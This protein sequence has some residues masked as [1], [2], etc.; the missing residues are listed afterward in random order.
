MQDGF[1]TNTTHNSTIHAV[2]AC[3][4]EG[5]VVVYKGNQ[6]GDGTGSTLNR[7][8]LLTETGDISVQ[9]PR[10]VDGH[11][12]PNPWTAGTFLRVSPRQTG[13]APWPGVGAVFREY[14]MG[15]AQTLSAAQRAVGR[16]G[17]IIGARRVLFRLAVRLGR[18]VPG[19]TPLV[20]PHHPAQMAVIVSTDPSTGPLRHW[21]EKDPQGGDLPRPEGADPE[22]NSTNTTTPPFQPDARRPRDIGTTAGP[23]GP[24]G[25][26]DSD[27][28]MIA[29]F[30]TL[31]TGP[32]DVAVFTQG[33]PQD[34]VGLT[35]GRSLIISSFSSSS[36]GRRLASLK[37]FLIS[38]QGKC[39][40][41]LVFLAIVFAEWEGR[42]I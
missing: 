13:W 28:T 35:G 2:P 11:R 25:A 40:D 17:P 27:T 39:F 14:Q 20:C 21:S 9:V 8:D 1:T 19:S 30:N 3:G 16:G 33:V 37:P 42:K 32:T 6:G 5:G 22:A 18:T 38:G 29:I 10:V 15:Q 26:E 23:R 36:G 7:K 31:A 34:P 41:C 12:W 24:G 4:R